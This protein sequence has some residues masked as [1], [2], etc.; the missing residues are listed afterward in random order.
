M[1]IKMRFKLFRDEKEWRAKKICSE[2]PQTLSK[3]H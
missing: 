3:G 1:N 2:I